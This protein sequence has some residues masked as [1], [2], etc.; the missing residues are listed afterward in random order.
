M[1]SRLPLGICK[2]VLSPNGSTIT[3]LDPLST[4]LQLNVFVGNSA[5]SC[6]LSGLGSSL[7]KSKLCS[8]CDKPSVLMVNDKNLGDTLKLVTLL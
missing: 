6:P 2:T 4:P 8:S 1:A 3:I 7:V 5:T